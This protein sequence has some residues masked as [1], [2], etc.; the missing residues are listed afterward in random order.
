MTREEAVEIALT[1]SSPIKCPDCKYGMKT[2]DAGSVMIFK[3]C[4]SCCTIGFIHT[5]RYLSA[6]KLLGLDPGKATA[7]KN[8]FVYYCEQKVRQVA[9]EPNVQNLRHEDNDSGRSRGNS[10]MLTTDHEPW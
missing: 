5:D 3:V 8:W 10:I 1:E 2:T 7:P 9:L 4:E 6:C